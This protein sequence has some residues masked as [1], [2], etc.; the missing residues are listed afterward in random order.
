MF[1]NIGFSS[2]E[3]IFILLVMLYFFLSVDKIDLHVEVKKYASIALILFLKRSQEIIYFVV[4]IEFFYS[5][6][7]KLYKT[8]LNNY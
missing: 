6:T 4:F 5:V 1:I 7:D 2:F 8:N 3:M